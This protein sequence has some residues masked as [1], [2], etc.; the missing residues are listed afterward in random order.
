[1]NQKPQQPA[2]PDLN[3]L[4]HKSVQSLAS[5]NDVFCTALQGKTAI[6]TGGAT[7]LGYCI[8][9]RLC[10]AGANVVI[11]S[12]NELRGKKAEKEF[13]D[14]GYHVRW[15]QADVSRVASC[16]D[17]VAFAE[18][19]FG[20][21]DILVA[22]AAGWASYAYLDVPE[23]VFDHV[24]D[25]D[26]KGAYFMGQ[27]AA[28]SMVRNQT[29]G[30]IVFIS[31]AAHLG[32]GQKGICM[33]SFYIAAK[34]GVSAMTRG[35]ASELHQYG[36]GVNCVAPGGMLSHGACTQGSEAAALYGEEYVKTSLSHRGQS[37]LATTPDQVALAV[38]ALCTSMSDFMVGETIDINGGTLMNMQEKPFSFTV[39]GC[40]PGPKKQ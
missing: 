33:N 3:E 9:N 30:K 2:M 20:P 8:V 25:T 28:R 32:E 18:K 13:C 38:F 21:V 16:Y 34:A 22:N 23:D 17:V 29:K 6:V 12:R 5:L 35:I 26:L 36:I 37:P 4:A 40:I 24:V 31:S 14:R 15:T 19:T 11:A 1:M 7:G 10:E 27:A 39:E